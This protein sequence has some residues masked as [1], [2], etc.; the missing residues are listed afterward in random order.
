MTALGLV[1]EVAEQETA[2]SSPSSD[3]E[4][5]GGQAS[6]APNGRFP[7]LLPLRYTVRLEQSRRVVTG[8]AP[9]DLSRADRLPTR[10]TLRLFIRSSALRQG[11]SPTAP[12]VVSAPLFIKHGL[13]NK[14][15]AIFL[16]SIERKNSSNTPLSPK[17]R[18]LEGL[19]EKPTK[20]AR[21][22]KPAR[23]PMK[24]PSPGKP[25]AAVLTPKKPGP[26]DSDSDCEV[27][28]NIASSSKTKNVL[29]VTLSPKKNE[30]HSKLSV[31]LSPTKISAAAADGD[32][33]DSDDVKLSVLAKSPKKLSFCGGGQPGKKALFGKK[34]ASSKHSAK[35]DSKQNEKQKRGRKPKDKGK[36]PK[37]MGKP[38]TSKS[39]KKAM[40]QVS[41]LEMGKKKRG[42]PRKTEEKDMKQ[43][44]LFD[45][46]KRKPPKPLS[47][48]PCVRKLTRELEAG[49]RINI[50]NAYL[51]MCVKVLRREQYALIKHEP[52]RELIERRRT[53]VD[54]QRL[55][56]RMTAEQK[57]EYMKRKKLELDE[58]R[59]AR[60]NEKRM[61]F[62]DQTLQLQPLRLFGDV[63]MVTEFVRA[64]GGL[65]MPQGV[66][67]LSSEH[68]MLAL[69]G[70]QAHHRL[71]LDVITM[72][73]KVL[74]NDEIAEVSGRPRDGRTRI[75]ASDAPDHD[76]TIE[77][78]LSDGVLARLEQCELFELTTDERV[79]VLR[80][81]VHRLLGTYSLAEYQDEADERFRRVWTRKLAIYRDR[82]AERLREGEQGEELTPGAKRSRRNVEAARR[83]REQ[84][85]K[86]ARERRLQELERHQKEQ[87]EAA[88]FREFSQYRVSPP[89]GAA[90]S[91]DDDDE[92]PLKVV[93]RRAASERTVHER[94]R[95]VLVSHKQATTP[96]AG[97]NRWFCYTSLVQ[98]DRLVA[99]LAEKGE[100][101]SALRGALAGIRAHLVST[102]P[103]CDSVPEQS[104]LVAASEQG[105][106]VAAATPAKRATEGTADNSVK[107]EPD[108]VAAGENKASAGVET[109]PAVQADAGALTAGNGADTRAESKA[110]D[111]TKPFLLG[112]LKE[113]ILS[114]EEELS[115]GWLGAVPG[116]ADWAA[117]VLS[118]DS[119]AQLADTVLECQRHI[120]RHA[121]QGLMAP[122]PT[123]GGAPSASEIR[124]LQAVRQCHTFSRLHV[125]VGLL[126]SSIKWDLSTATKVSQGCGAS[127]RHRLGEG[128]RER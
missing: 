27:L 12:W 69:A 36:D 111:E 116:P 2:S 75:G 108:V 92:Q 93:Q 126:D 37:R 54:E 29:K 79:E 23:S 63:A 52:T 11:S 53:K 128:N 34:T 65:L 3:K 8:L 123:G 76:S 84:R 87:D 78:E 99:A 43:M 72:M 64:Y 32:S 74:V 70:R 121:L 125:L 98:V 80:V 1:T 5:K 90:A 106:A 46:S 89:A 26:P 40:K 102:L 60:L 73:L 95:V 120:D 56:S 101:E 112:T 100:R 110:D 16:P 68:L 109:D 50:H 41:L 119:P 115:E 22:D 24:G 105:T 35:G 18:K 17:K 96:A 47:L 117:R 107:L 114:I 103:A 85:E 39:Q 42:R 61:R 113:D 49:K 104:L 81:L 38:G 58:E 10:D 66:Q 14:I 28:A 30:C 118:A 71:L 91:D 67:P 124:W 19:K 13:K 51:N 77:D 55:L 127:S 97:E 15:A 83:E 44:S 33:D 6:P 57:D 59:R 48:P 62:E 7:S 82:K 31:M 88:A 4:N 122:G 45:L 86:E 9:A 20:K 21:S 25:N 94:G